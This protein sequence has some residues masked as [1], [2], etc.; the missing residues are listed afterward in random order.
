[1]KE[2]QSLHLLRGQVE[3]GL[4]SLLSRDGAV[5]V[6]TH[7]LL[8]LVWPTLTLIAGVLEATSV[9]LLPVRSG[10]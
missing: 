4:G 3:V 5:S 10:H 7:T 2:L 8:P 1:M 6:M 9:H